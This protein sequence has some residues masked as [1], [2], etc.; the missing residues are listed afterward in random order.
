MNTTIFVLSLLFT[1]QSSVRKGGGLRRS[2]GASIRDLRMVETST[3]FFLPWP[4]LDSSTSN[5]VQNEVQQIHNK[6][7]YQ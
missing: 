4:E 2:F 1:R 6:E 3:L 7:I 5:F